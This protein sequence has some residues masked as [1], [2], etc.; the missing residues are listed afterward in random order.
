MDDGVFGR[1]ESNGFC[2]YPESGCESQWAYEH[3]GCVEPSEGGDDD[4]E[5]LPQGED[6]GD[7][8][9]GLETEDVDPPEADGDEGRVEQGLVLLYDFQLGAGDIVLDRSGVEPLAPLRLQGEGYAWI[10]DGMRFTGDTDTRAATETAPTKLLQACADTDELTV[11]AWTTPAAQLAAGPRRIATLS[12]NAG[13]RNFTLGQGHHT[14]IETDGWL[15][16]LRTTEEENAMNG[17]PQVFVQN[18]INPGV[19]EHIVFTHRAN[20]DEAF[21]RNG[22]LET[23]HVARSMEDEGPTGMVWDRPGGFEGWDGSY[24]FA[25]GN[26]LPFEAEGE[27]LNRA[28]QG[29]V[30]LVAVYCRALDSSE[31]ATNFSAGL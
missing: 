23:A 31:V 17:L 10:E 12:E 11:E 18:T 28:Y 21:F 22:E 9:G 2:S 8:D 29:D 25:I 24:R 6:D 14:D 19:L 26:E 3:G 15:F 4:G 7:G 20:G 16:R 30:H 27:P 1:C 13:K 5:T